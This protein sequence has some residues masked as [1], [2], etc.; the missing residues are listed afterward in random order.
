MTH[1]KLLDKIDY[2]VKIDKS[3]DG[4]MGVANWTEP[5]RALYAAVELHKP[6]LYPEDDCIYCEEDN[7]PYPCGTIQFIEKEMK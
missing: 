1:D 5:A 2:F 6:F 7:Q 3:L 4:T